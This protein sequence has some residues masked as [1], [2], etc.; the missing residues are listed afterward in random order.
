MEHLK[1]RVAEKFQFEN[2][3]IVVINIFAFFQTV[4]KRTQRKKNA[5]EAQC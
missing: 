3:D 5:L 2:F 1:L 4:M